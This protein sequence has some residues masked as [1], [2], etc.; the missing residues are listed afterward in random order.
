MISSATL[1]ARIA[2]GFGNILPHEIGK[3]SG[4]IAAHGRVIGS[5]IRAFGAFN[6]LAI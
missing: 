1:D 2:Q 3:E 6:A 5:I 4:A